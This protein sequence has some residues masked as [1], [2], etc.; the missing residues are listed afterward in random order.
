MMSS[1]FNAGREM[2]R[3][4]NLFGTNTNVLGT[5]IKDQLAQNTPPFRPPYNP[6]PPTPTP[7][8]RSHILTKCIRSR[9]NDVMEI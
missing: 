2:P 3:A 7:A 5:Q 9:S 4:L 8:P 6:S 1:A